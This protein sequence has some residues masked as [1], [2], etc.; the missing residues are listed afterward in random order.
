MIG[1]SRRAIRITGEH[2]RI[3]LELCGGV[4]DQRGLDVRDRGQAEAGMAE[5]RELNGETEPVGVAAVR[6]DECEVLAIKGV[7]SRKRVAVDWH[8]EQEIALRLA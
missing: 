1:S 8:A 2:H 7:E 3:D 4:G 5:Q 6:G